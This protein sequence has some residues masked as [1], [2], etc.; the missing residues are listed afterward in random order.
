MS[1]PL[2]KILNPSDLEH[3]EMQFPLA[4]LEK[5]AD[6]LHQAGVLDPL[7]VEWRRWEYGQAL[8]ALLKAGPNPRVLEVGGSTSLFAPTVIGSGLCSTFR[9]MECQ[10]WISNQGAVDKLFKQIHSVA[11][12]KVAYP[13]FSLGSTFE[14]VFDFIA[15]ISVIENLPYDGNK[16]GIWHDGHTFMREF[17]RGLV[18][19]L[20]PNGVLFLTSDLKAEQPDNAH[21]HWMRPPG[22]WTPKNWFHLGEDLISTEQMEWVMADVDFGWTGHEISPGWGYTFASAALRRLP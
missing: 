6:K 12:E 21:W 20:A 1:L 2:T 10:E 4:L 8:R 7:P 15:C 3:E 19:L 16:E 18:K 5:T 9:Q 14:G 22:I 13:H 17:V 11:P